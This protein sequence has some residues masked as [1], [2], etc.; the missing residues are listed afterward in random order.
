MSESQP[1]KKKIKYRMD[2]EQRKALIYKMYPVLLLGSLIWL[3]A[4]FLFSY[5]FSDLEFTGINLIFY[6]IVVVVVVNLFVL[7]YFTSKNNKVILSFLI[8]VLFHYG[9]PD[10]NGFCW[11]FFCVIRMRH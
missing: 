3:S 8:F 11:L 1:H 9:R 7:F 2:E 6:I 5:L 4:E 10:N